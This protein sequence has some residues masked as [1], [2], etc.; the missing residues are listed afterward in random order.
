[1]RALTN[2]TL[3]DGTGRDPVTRATV[4]I[5]DAG[6]ITHAGRIRT[7]PKAAAVTDVAGR[8][9]MPSMIDCHV[10]LLIDLKPL[11]DRALTPLSL[12]V[13]EG[14][15]HARSTIDAGIT[16]VRDAGGTPL[17]V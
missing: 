17:G 15:A 12:L 2:A 8:T 9:V 7:I 16:S 13:L 5:D 1:M 3:I 14:A 11:Q 10:H 4:L 6:R